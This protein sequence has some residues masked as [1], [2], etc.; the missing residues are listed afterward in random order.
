MA[1]VLHEC[2]PEVKVEIDSQIARL[3]SDLKTNQEPR[4]FIEILADSVQ[5][6]NKENTSFRVRARR[7]GF[8]CWEELLQL[9]QQ[10]DHYCIVLYDLV[11]T[12]S[13]GGNRRKLIQVIWKAEHE[14]DYQ[15]RLRLNK[16]I[17]DRMVTRLMADNTTDL[18]NGM[19]EL[20]RNKSAFAG[21]P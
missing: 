12:L 18:R 4:G 20:L 2:S 19:R 17:P 15:V 10:N 16:C 1:M 21:T 7:Y 11:Y 14:T 9:V 5:E 3:F 8:I 6:K 13:G